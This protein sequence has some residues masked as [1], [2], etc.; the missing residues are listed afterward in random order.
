MDNRRQPHDQHLIGILLIDGYALMSY[1]SV[2]EPLRAANLL[3][4]RELYRVCNIPASGDTARSSSG[5]VVPANDR[6]G[7]EAGFSMVLIVAGG[8]PAAY[9]DERVFDWLRRLARQGTVLGG[10]SGGPVILASAGLMKGRRMTVHWEHA[11]ALTEISPSLLIERSLYVIDR[12]RVT[13]AGGTAPMDLMHALIT[14]HHGPD[15]A[16]RVSDW[17]MHTEIRPSGGPQRAGRVVRYK[18]TD[19]TVLRAIEAMENHVADPLELRQLAAIAGVSLRQLNRL[20]RNK[21]GESTIRF[22]RNLRLEKARN[23]LTDSSLRITEVALA[24]G[25]A[26]SGHFSAAFAERYG[27]PPSS[28]R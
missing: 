28:Y 13:C 10:V 19:A 25:F 18:T 6:V 27:S 24:T 7:S 2:V 12:D 15:L 1:A 14:E 16:R 5:A 22:Y 3:A 23:L 4:G 8:S 9:D 21:I 17:Y 26:N 11:A 20:F